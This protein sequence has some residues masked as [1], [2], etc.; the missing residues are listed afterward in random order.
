MSQL[1]DSLFIVVSLF[2][3]VIVAATLGIMLSTFNTAIQS[4]DVSEVA[5]TGTASMSSQ[6]GGV[7]DWFFVALLIGM[8]LAAMGLAALNQV[9]PFFFYMVLAV[10]LLMV[11][12][13]WGFQSA[14]ENIIA[15]GT[16]FGAY[17]SSDMPLTT[18]IMNNFGLYSM[19]I[20]LLTG[21]GT[22]VKSRQE[23]RGFY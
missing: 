9:P 22:Y 14:F 15:S 8:P 10:L 21:I 7:M 19:L 16:T 23:P 6:W 12:I 5:K 17:L 1:H 4:Q 20:V 11:F 2:L 18:F 3:F 13:G